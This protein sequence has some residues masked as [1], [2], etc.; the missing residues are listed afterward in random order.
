MKQ[1][2]VFNDIIWIEKNIGNYVLQNDEL[3]F[4]KRYYKVIKLKMKSNTSDTCYV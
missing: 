1:V 2:F 3:L 4:K